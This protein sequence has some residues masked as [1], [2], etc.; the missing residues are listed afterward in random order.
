MNLDDLAI[1]SGEPIRKTPM[2]RRGFAFGPAEQKAVAEVF[3]Y[4]A[5]L[6]VDFGYQ[7][8]FEDLYA[9]AFLRYQG[10]EGYANAVPLSL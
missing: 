5:K 2:P 7:G 9:D 4:Y 6:G 10:G 1:K 8:Y 3:E